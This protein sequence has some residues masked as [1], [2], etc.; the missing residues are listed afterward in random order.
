M[1]KQYIGYIGSYTKKESQGVYRFTLDTEKKQITNVE[2]AANLDNPTY[3][4]IS[5]NNQYVYAVS[6][7][8]EQGGI[9]AF[10]INDETGTLDRI[11]SQATD[12]SA[13]CHV[14]VDRENQL[15]V[16]ANYHTK[17]VEAFLTNEDGSLQPPKAIEHEG[18]GPH[19][20]QEKPHL[21]FAGYTPD[22]QYVV[23]VDLGSDTITTYRPDGD[24]LQEV[25][26]LTVK[27]GSGPR[28]I[29]FHPKAS[30]AYVMTELSNE[31]IVLKYHEKEGTFEEVQYIS[32]LPG[33]FN[34]NSQGSA[35]H[36]SSDGKFVYAG[37]RG[38]NSIAIYRIKEDYTVEFLEWTHTEGDW[39][40][41]FVLDPTEQFIVAANQ[42]SG[43]LVLFERDQEK[44]T[45]T[46]LQKDVQAP[47]AVCVKFLN[48]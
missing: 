40:R 36:L 37:N 6:K 33:D 46:L 21:H 18:N 47:E 15:V 10:T 27:P 23:V 20:R 41:D 3:L 17:Q 34:E 31:V 22:E 44:G 35:I 30:Y 29:A 25:S 48:Y 4:T 16:T 1:G 39:P 13:P 26:V 32:T 12:D 38:H 2:V 11:N 5:N 28:H 24:V 45:L 7:E 9:T 14:S 19:E 43:T 42:E 8:G